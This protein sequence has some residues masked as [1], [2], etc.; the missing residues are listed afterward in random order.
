MEERQQQ[1]IQAQAREQLS[2]GTHTQ[3]LNLSSHLLQKKKEADHFSKL[4]ES[5]IPKSSSRYL[6]ILPDM[7]VLIVVEWKKLFGRMN[8]L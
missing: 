4:V 7:H 1:L 8:V 3:N 5:G 2:R 6:S